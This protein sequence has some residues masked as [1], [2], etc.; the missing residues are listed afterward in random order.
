MGAVVRLGSASTWL[1]IVVFSNLWALALREWRGTSGRVHRLIVLGILVL[2]AST[3]V[4]GAGNYL[5]TKAG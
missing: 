3:V 2:I 1:F 4:V 5:G